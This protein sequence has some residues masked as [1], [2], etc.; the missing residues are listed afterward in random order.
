[1]KRFSNFLSFWSRSLR[2]SSWSLSSKRS[3]GEQ[4]FLGLHLAIGSIAFLF[5]ACGD[6]VT[7][8]V[9]QVS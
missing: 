5:A 2:Q 6:E 7:T 9:I 8:Q 3:G 4:L 1:M